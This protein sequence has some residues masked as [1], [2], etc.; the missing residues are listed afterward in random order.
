MSTQAFLERVSDQD[1][2]AALALLRTPGTHINVDAQHPSRYRDTHFTTAMCIAVAYGQSELVKAMLDHGA[3]PNLRARRNMGGYPPLVL[4]AKLGHELTVQL[5]LEH[6]DTQVDAEAIFSPGAE[7]GM[8]ALLL[9]VEHGHP[10]IVRRLLDM[11]A[12]PWAEDPYGST[13]FHLAA[14]RADRPLFD[15]LMEAVSPEEHPT[16]LNQMGGPCE[17]TTAFL[18]WM[19]HDPE[20][21]L[22]LIDRGA[23]PTRKTSE[24]K[25]A[26]HMAFACVNPV[27]NHV[28]ETL[29]DT[30]GLDLQASEEN[31]RKP[32]MGFL[33]SFT[34]L[35][36]TRPDLPP[37]LPERIDQYAAF[38]GDLQAVDDAGNSLIHAL[39]QGM[40][41]YPLTMLPGLR[42]LLMWGA[43]ADQINRAGQTPLDIAASAGA[44]RAAELLLTQANPSA[45]AIAD[46]V[47]RQDVSMVELLLSAKHLPA[48]DEAV[49]EATARNDQPM[50]ALLAAGERRLA[51]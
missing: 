17:D 41:P 5:L 47:A 34:R 1:F 7:N 33:Q 45:K 10:G 30:H 14:E 23:N 44:H 9:A 27:P 13:A 39:L 49:A 6:P 38:G 40:R 31:G 3:D 20:Y 24:G 12:S 26:M 11:N 8:T 15:M 28:L 51:A 32:M 42:R 21:A 50:L 4:A 22:T 25:T 48:L 16:A 43:P 35:S 2:D 36:A 37:V 19:K 18:L 29:R 46:A